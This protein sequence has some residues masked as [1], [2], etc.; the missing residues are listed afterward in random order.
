MQSMTSEMGKVKE[1]EQMEPRIIKSEKQYRQF[2]AEVERLTEIDPEPE[3]KDGAR[4][5]LLAKLVEDYEKANFPFEKPDPIDAILFRMEQEGLKQ[6]DIASLLG[7]KN[8]ASEVLSRKRPLTIPMIRAL[9]HELEIPADLLIQEPKAKYEVSPAETPEEI[10]VQ[11]LVKRRWVESA[12]AATDFV[13]RLLSPVGSPVFMKNTMLF[14]TSSRTNRTNLW[15]WLAYVREI[16]DSRNYL[17]GRFRKEELNEELIRYVVRLSFMD[18][19]PRMACDFLEERGIA[20]VVL[21]H[22]PGTHLDGA[23]LLGRAGSPIIGL[24]VREDRLD[25]FW[26]TLVHELV[27]AWKHLDHARHRAI[28]DE[29]IESSDDSTAAMEKEANRIATEILIPRSEWK[30][31]EVHRNP[32]RKNIEALASRLQIDPSIV[33]GRLRFERKAFNLF[34]SLVGYRR[35]RV[36]FPDITWG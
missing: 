21:P 27:H 17:Q 31:S 2:L 5:E 23:A 15:L 6:K 30:R 29:N 12:E 10:P 36:N 26:F 20:V 14:G 33:A 11:L 28:V 13:K 35:V 9:H 34:S 24:S 22:L 32:S 1:S 18:R 25:N 3:S 19:G 8:R 16:A 4:L 7:G